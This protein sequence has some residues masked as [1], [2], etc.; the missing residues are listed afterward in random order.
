MAEQSAYRRIAVGLR[1][2][3]GAGEFGVAQIYGVERGAVELEI[4]P[5]ISGGGAYAS[6]AQ[7]RIA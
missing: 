1:E 3:I 4:V 5:D 6:L 2:L 7:M